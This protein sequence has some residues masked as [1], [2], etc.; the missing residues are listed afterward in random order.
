MKALEIQQ[1]GLDGLKLAPRTA[2]TPGHG[3]VRVRM[4]TASLNYRDLLTVL[5][6]YGPSYK[7]P[8]VPLSD[9]CGE[10]VETGPGVT[11][12]KAGDRVTTLFFRDWLAGRPEPQLLGTALGG[13]IDGCAAEEITLP[14]HAL[15]Q[16]PAHLSDLEAATLP[17]AGL[18]AWRALMTEGQLTAGETVLVQ[19]TGG[20]SIFALQFAKAAGAEVIVTSSSNDKLARAKAMGADHLLNYKETTSW[21]K[22]V[23]EITGGRGVEHVVE[24]GGA[25]TLGESLR[26]I[27]TGGHISV[28]GVLS[29][30]SKDLM[31][32]HVIGANARIIGISVGSR[33]NYAEMCRGVAL[34]KIKPVV[35]K[36][37]P[38]EDA[39]AAFEAMQGQG[40]FGKICLQ[41]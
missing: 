6:V 2:R 17:C 11:A 15:F 10:V 23:R 41:F 35:D 19:G 37:Y 3:E 33:E 5:G 38:F 4:R 18:T 20:V 13:L 34:H 12:L 14:A 24:V 30:P 9:G 40:H 39:R 1:Y 22:R 27:R 36:V 31:L 25:G 7:L 21:A 26:A 28:I 8:L 32:A 16:P 29:G